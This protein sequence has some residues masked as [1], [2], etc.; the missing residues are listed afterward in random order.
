MAQLQTAS[1]DTEGGDA[2]AAEGPNDEDIAGAEQNLAE[3][4]YVLELEKTKRSKSAVWMIESGKMVSA[5]QGIEARLARKSSEMD[6]KTRQTLHNKMM[7]L[8]RQLSVG[9]QKFKEENEMLSH[10]QMILLQ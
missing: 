3:R 6:E 9:N 5:I 2:E 10:R 7:D 4:D 8:R 1:S